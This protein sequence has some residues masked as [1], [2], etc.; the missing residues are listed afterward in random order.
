MS[1]DKINIDIVSLLA[2]SGRVESGDKSGDKII[3]RVSMNLE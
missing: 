3:E 2:L 1:G